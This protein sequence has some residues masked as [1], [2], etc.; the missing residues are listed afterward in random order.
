MDPTY[1][2]EFLIGGARTRLATSPMGDSYLETL[3]Q[4]HLCDG[5]PI[6]H[7]RFRPLDEPELDSL[8]QKLEP[9]IEVHRFS[10]ELAAEAEALAQKASQ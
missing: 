9:L 6:E 8:R 4:D 2:P 10:V 7:W 3:A 5:T 1:S